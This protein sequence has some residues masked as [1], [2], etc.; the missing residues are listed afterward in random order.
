MTNALGRMPFAA[1]VNS[2]DGEVSGDESFVPGRNGESGSVI[3]D[4]K[5]HAGSRPAASRLRLAANSRDQLK[6][7]KWQNETNILCGAILSR[8]ANILITGSRLQVTEIQ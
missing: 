4:A 3:P 7:F 6:L 1:E 5:F 8:S 2:L